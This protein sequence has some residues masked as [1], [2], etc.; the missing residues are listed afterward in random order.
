MTDRP[1]VEEE[2]GVKSTGVGGK[3]PRL[4]EAGVKLEQSYKWNHH[5]FSSRIKEVEVALNPDNSI[6]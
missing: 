4:A 2:S 1:M 3:Y 5:Q 6:K